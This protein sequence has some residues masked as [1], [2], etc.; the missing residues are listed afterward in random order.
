[1]SK[2][3]QQLQAPFKNSAKLQLLLCEMR[4]YTNCK[5]VSKIRLFSFFSCGLESRIVH[6]LE[7]VWKWLESFFM[8]FVAFSC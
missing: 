4:K 8:S 2:I 1:M 6:G 7:H 5:N 3:T